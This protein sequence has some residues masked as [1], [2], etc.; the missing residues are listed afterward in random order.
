M[1]EVYKNIYLKELA[2]PDNP[3]KYLNFYVIKG[4]EKSML[5]DTGFNCEDTKAEI[6][7]VF[8]ELS[9]EPESTILFLTHLHSDHTGLAAYFEKMGLVIY[10][11]KI[12][13]DLLNGSVDKS[14]PMW[15]NAIQHEFWQGLEEDRLII[16]DHPGFK[17]RPSGHINYIPATP[18]EHIQIGEYN[19]EIIDLKGHTPGIVGLYEK[20]HK[21]LFCGDHILG[22]ITP[23]ITFWGFQY[24]DL[25]G[26]YL[27]SLDLVYNLDVDHLFPSHRFLVE[28]HQKR[29]E[30]LYEHHA[31]RLEEARQ[32]LRKY[33][34]STVRTVTKQLHWD[35]RSKN[36][37]D[38]PKAQKW[39]AAGETHAHLEHLRAL[40]EAAMEEKDGIL[41]Y[42][43][44]K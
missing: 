7:K 10:A 33:G 34:K 4:A 27:D 17:F 5:I 18:G 8:E 43:M 3:L 42:S 19:F 6:M 23:N 37:D 13:G 39:F 22:K 44:I 25:L 20:E 32:A 41:Y 28:D 35:I 36:W 26:T 1:R 16:E 11:S 38:F 15:Q 31:K 29:I 2:L 12:D 24:G 9:L 30:E 40:G 14:D 21:I